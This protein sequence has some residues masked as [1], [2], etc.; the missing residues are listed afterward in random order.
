MSD[1][2]YLSE[3]E[4]SLDYLSKS[5]ESL[6]SSEGPYQVSSVA[7]DENGLTNDTFSALSFNEKK[8]LNLRMCEYC[9]KHYKQDMVVPYEEGQVCWHCIFCVNYD[10]NLRGLVDGLYGMTIA[11]YV[12]TCKDSHDKDACTKVGMC[13]LCDNL[14]GKFIDGIKNSEVINVNLGTEGTSDVSK[15]EGSEELSED[16]DEDEVVEITI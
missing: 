1:P 14:N 9:G 13:F 5:E 12:V 15:E 4:E 8:N 11:Q 10:P 16:Y 7:I 2:K 3:S 6:D